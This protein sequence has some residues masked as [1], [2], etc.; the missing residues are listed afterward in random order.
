MHGPNLVYRISLV[1]SQCSVYSAGQITVLTPVVCSRL[2]YYP[3]P[4]NLVGGWSMTKICA[5]RSGGGP[6][7]KD[8][9][10]PTVIFK[11]N[12]SSLRRCRTPAGFTST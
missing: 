2:Q 9:R 11:S 6:D 4:T 10:T 5:N 7:D 12:P 3:D 8:G 1:T